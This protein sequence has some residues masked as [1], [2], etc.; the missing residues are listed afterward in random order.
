MIKGVKGWW[1]DVFTGV[2]GVNGRVYLTSYVRVIPFI[3]G[4]APFLTGPSHP[5]PLSYINNVSCS[6]L[7]VS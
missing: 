4:D 5:A 7:H 2:R 3:V 6:F 1:W